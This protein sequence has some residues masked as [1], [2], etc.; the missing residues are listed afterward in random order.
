MQAEATL[1]PLRA[2]VWDAGLRPA[3]KAPE[4]RPGGSSRGEARCVR[5][6]MLLLSEESQNC[7]EKLGASKMTVRDA[8]ERWEERLKSSI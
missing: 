6:G 7:A 4:K 2:G 8:V 5:S 1:F 3:A